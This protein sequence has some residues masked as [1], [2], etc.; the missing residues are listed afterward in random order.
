MY[1]RRLNVSGRRKRM[2]IW[3]DDR[4]EDRPDDRRDDDPEWKLGLNKKYNYV[5]QICKVEYD[6]RLS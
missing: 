4:S 3:T 2:V 6:A 5:N 1:R